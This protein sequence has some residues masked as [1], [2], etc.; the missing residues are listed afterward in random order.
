LPETVSPEIRNLIGKL[1]CKEVKD[2]PNAHELM[3]EPE[4]KK[5]LLRI[6]KEIA[7]YDVNS[8]QAIEDQ[9]EKYIPPY[10]NPMRIVTDLCKSKCAT[11]EEIDFLKSILSD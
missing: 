6:V 10:V 3:Q 7:S 9:L 2:R 8:A 4:I 11:T 1:L 5:H